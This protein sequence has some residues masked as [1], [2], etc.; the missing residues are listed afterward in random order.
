MGYYIVQGGR[1]IEGEF[2]ARGSKNATLPILAACV[3]AEDE[4][5]LGNCPFIRDVSLTLD[6]LRELG[7]KVERTGR[8]V[9]VD[10]RSMTG[11]KVSQETVRKMRSSILFLGA[12]LGRT[13]KAALGHPGGC[14][15]GKRPI[16]LHLCAFEKM[17]V[18]VRE[19]SGLIDCE[20]PHILGYNIYL[21]FPS[22]GATENILLL[23]VR[24]E[25]V[26]VIHNAAREPE[27]VALAQFLRACG[28][29]IYGEGTSSIMVE[30]VQ[31][32]HG[33][34][35]EIPADRIE[36]GTFL[37]A[38][39]MTGGELCLK[40]L[41]R[42]QMEAVQRVMEQTGCR[43]CWGKGD[44]WMRPPKRLSSGFSL[45]TG[46]FPC[47]PTDMQP[48]IMSLLT[49]AKGNCM[50]SE[51]VFEARYSHGMELCRMGA[52]IRIDGRTALLHGVGRL[53]GAEVFG[54]D[55][56]GGAALLLAALAAEGESI[57][58]G[59]QFVERG[60]ERIEDAFS[61]LGGKVRLAE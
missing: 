15:I 42:E 10:S 14:A 59:S 32:L 51:T 19:R 45:E 57:V 18:Q 53:H 31:K 56:R 52:D 8:M 35:F 30:G 23:A 41:E 20:A 24:A 21:D 39:A 11:T 47:F 27:V 16:D 33:A 44:L 9:T 12:L 43:F 38:A 5:V 37:C 26:T 61:S 1:K 4:V 22:V 50:I 25:G 55:L 58:H 60:Y 7:C 2:A 40:G 46:P 34:Y 3:L 28:A 36:G 54:K 17:G 6:I 49:L 13:G 29:E 48:P